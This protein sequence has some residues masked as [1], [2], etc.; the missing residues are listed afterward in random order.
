MPDFGLN[1]NNVEV[2]GKSTATGDGVTT[3]FEIT[4]G[5]SGISASTSY[6]WV[7]CSSHAIART[8]TIDGTKIYIVFASA[9]AS[10]GANNVIIYWRLI[11]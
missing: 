10:G 4:H 2:V 5:V 1:F 6:C 11:P 7:D 3:E 8:W 9:P